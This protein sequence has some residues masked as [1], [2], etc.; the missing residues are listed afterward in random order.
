MFGIFKKGEITVISLILAKKILSLFLMIFMGAL[1][2]RL[3]ILQPRDSKLLSTLVLNLIMPCMT[4]SAFQVTYSDS[5]RSGLLLAAA[6]AIALETLTILAAEGM[7]KLLHMDPVEKAASVYSN[8]GNMVIPIV[9]SMLGPQYVIYTMAYSSIQQFLFWSHCKMTI[10]G[11]KKIDLKK[12]F[13]NV[14]MI[15]V[16]VGILMFFLR[17]Q[18]PEMIQEAVSGIGGMIGPLSMVITGMLIGSMDLKKV[19]TYR[20]V[21]L[22]A[23][24][25][26]IVYP[27]LAVLLMKPFTAF[28]PEMKT[29]LMIPMLAAAAPTAAT[30]TQMS[31]VYGKDAD[32]ASA[33][34]VVTT[35]MCVF[36]MPVII[37]LY[38]L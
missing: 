31:Q 37:F 5:I 19:F 28:A 6:A 32:Y 2:V 29:V 35:L 22:V 30:V 18:L 7:N 33:C 38:Q 11:E 17:L 23:G 9:T 21:W 12:I 24:L 26:L 3:H 34:N 36:T 13:L 4:L 8:A 27:L 15:V 14:N 10:C 1:L 16:F 25:R 20:R